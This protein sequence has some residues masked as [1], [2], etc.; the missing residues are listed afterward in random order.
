MKKPKYRTVDAIIAR[1]V[2][3]ETGENLTDAGTI[4][5]LWAIAMIDY[6]GPVGDYA[7]HKMRELD[8]EPS[9]WVGAIAFLTG[10]CSGAQD[11][12]PI[13]DDKLETLIPEDLRLK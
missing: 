1:T 3:S 12:F 8:A 7:W 5:A 6:R 9:V 11:A 4:S 2:A 13:T 10:F